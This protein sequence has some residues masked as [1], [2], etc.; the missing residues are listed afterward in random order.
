MQEQINGEQNEGKV[1]DR[2]NFFEDT[3]TSN[4]LFTFL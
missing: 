3:S 4:K 1:E 2:L